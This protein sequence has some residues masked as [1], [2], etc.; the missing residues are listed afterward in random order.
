MDTLGVLVLSMVV[1]VPTSLKENARLR[2]KK[3]TIARYNCVTL[4]EARILKARIIK[5]NDQLDPDYVHGEW[6]VRE[7]I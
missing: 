3:Q 1:T 5:L 6:T 4:E 2:F 7:F